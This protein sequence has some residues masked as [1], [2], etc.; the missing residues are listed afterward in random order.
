[1]ASQVTTL[2]E[3]VVDGGYCI[4]CGACAAVAGS[5]I[6]MELDDSGRYRPR[7]DGSDRDAPVLAV[8]PF[9]NEGEH[10]GELGARLFGADCEP[11]DR[12]GFH[13][14]TYAGHVAEDGYRAAGS[15]GGVGTWVLV[16]LLR[17]DMV[18]AVL[19]VRPRSPDADDSRLFEFTVSGT[20]DELRERAKSR[21]YPV[22]MSEA[23][24]RVRSEAARYAMVGVPCYVKALRR[25]AASD[26]LIAERVKV[27]LA[28]VCGHLKST[29]FADSFAWQAG[30]EP[31]RLDSVDFRRKLS[32]RPANRY[33]ME[34]HGRDAAGE[35]RDVVSPTDAFFGS[36]WGHG[37]FKYEACDY[38][39]DVLGETAD[40]TVGDAWLPEYVEDSAGTNVVVVRR[41]ELAALV[42]AGIADGRLALEPLSP[43][44]VAASQDAGLRHRREGLSYRLALKDRAA[45][46]RPRKR[47]PAREDHLAPRQRSIFAWRVRLARES[48]RAFARALAAGD[49]RLFER[50]MTPL[51][52]AHDLQYMPRWRALASRL[53]WFLKGRPGPA[54]GP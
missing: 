8:C 14:R 9:T 27:T 15:S 19:H 52:R 49:P 42:E 43:D 30:I 46:W 37:F 16:E 47:V 18:D 36:N 11:H 48:H 1:V 33:G 10:E 17:R 13:M 39:D 40:L 25:L 12:I 35:R 5:P 53:K 31:G 20:E 23:L 34:M 24:A 4:G 41:P 26:P 50:E 21:Y 28:L 22:E 51:V 32:G 44:A 45:K 54:R 6:R 38:C 7:L 29:R 2:F 3:T